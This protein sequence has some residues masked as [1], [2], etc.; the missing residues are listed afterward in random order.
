MNEAITAQ[1]ARE[2]ATTVLSEKVN[3][4]LQR[5]E[6]VIK[7]AVKNNKLNCIVSG[8]MEALTKTELERRGFVV[9]TDSGDQRDPENYVT[10]SW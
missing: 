4:Q 2:T 1:W 7:E 3:G 6:T 10:I 9:K 8:K 5:C